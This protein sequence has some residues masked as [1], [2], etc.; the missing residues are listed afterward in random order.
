MYYE[1]SEP[2]AMALTV[3]HQTGGRSSQ[4]RRSHAILEVRNFMCAHIKR[5]DQVSRRLVQYLSMQTHELLVLVR[6]ADT[7]RLL[8]TPPEE[9]RWLMR[10][11]SGLGRASKKAWNVMKSVGPQFF[12]EMDQHREWHF[13]FKEYYD[14][15]VVR[16]FL[17][18]LLPFPCNHSPGKV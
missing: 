5:D 7:G 4:F 2:D 9:E 10:E 11:K 3:R 16:V 13:S 14:V 17:E 15:Y 8:I 6:D 1:T 12:E 18:H